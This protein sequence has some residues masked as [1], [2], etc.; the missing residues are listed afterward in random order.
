MNRELAV[1]RYKQH[2]PEGEFLFPAPG[3]A[4]GASS[5]AQVPQMDLFGAPKK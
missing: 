4:D 5:E 3:H 2:D 1:E